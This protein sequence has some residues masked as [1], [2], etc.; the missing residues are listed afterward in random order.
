MGLKEYLLDSN[1][2]IDHFGNRL[3]KNFFKSISNQNIFNCN[4]SV[5]TKIEI[6]GYKL[7]N[8]SINKF[9]EDSKIIDL[10]DQIVDKTIEI[11]KNHKIKIADAIIAA[12]SLIHNFTLITHNIKD[13]NKINQMKIIDPYKQ[14]SIESNK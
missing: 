11:R 10:H 4:I 14:F 8:K 7:E 5:I 3:P 12:T 9:I 13:F 6:L 1:V 2:I